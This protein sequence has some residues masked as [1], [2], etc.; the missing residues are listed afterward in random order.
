MTSGQKVAISLL[1]AI[2]V[3]AAFAVLSF[4]KLFSVVETRFYQNAIVR[5]VNGKLADVSA[6]LEQY[7]NDAQKKFAPLAENP[8]VKSSFTFDQSDENIKGRE[9]AFGALMNAVP[10]LSGVRII[11]KNGK[12]IHYSTFTDDILQQ[13]DK[14]ISYRLYA[15]INE[16]AYNEIDTA[17]E[18]AARIVCDPKN[19]RILYCFPLYDSFFV[20]RGTLV[21]YTAS[22]DFIREA[23]RRKLVRFTDKAVFAGNRKKPVFVFGLPN[24]ISENLIDAVNKKWEQGTSAIERIGENEKS[25][26]WVLLS[27]SGNSFASIENVRIYAAWLYPENLFVFSDSLKILLLLSVFVSTLLVIFLIFNIKSDDMNIIRERIKRFQLAVINEYVAAKTEVDWNMVYADMSRRKQEVREGIKRS[28]GSR[29]KRRSSEVDFLLD[30]SWNEIMAVLSAQSGIQS[31]GS[32]DVTA[33]QIKDLLEQI[34]L[35]G[36]VHSVQKNQSIQNTVYPAAQAEKNVHDASLSVERLYPENTQS[37]VLLSAENSAQQT[38][39][40]TPAQTLPESEAVL[41][42][43]DIDELEE[44]GELDEVEELEDFEDKTEPFGPVENV[45]PVE[46]KPQANASGDAG[47]EPLDV[48]AEIETEDEPAA[49]PEAV[50]GITADKPAAEPET[51]DIFAD[52]TDALSVGGELCVTETEPDTPA[53]GETLAVI[54]ETDMFIEQD[55]YIAGEDTP[56]TDTDIFAGGNTDELAV[57][58][59]E[60]IGTEAEPESVVLQP[61][62]EIEPETIDAETEFVAIAESESSAMVNADES[63]AAADETEAF[64]EAADADAGAD[65]AVSEIT[66][67]ADAE[68]D[69]ADEPAASIATTPEIEIED[70]PVAPAAG[71]SQTH[72]KPIPVSV[73]Q[74]NIVL[75]NIESET[76]T[77]ADSVLAQNDETDDG[78]ASA[79]FL[80]EL[81]F[82]F[83]LGKMAPPPSGLLLK[84]AAESILEKDGLFV[85]A[86]EAE[87]DITPADLNSEFQELVDSVLKI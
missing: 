21:F 29:A 24:G 52:G 71:S 61:A 10:A 19:E 37:T 62:A 49:A 51:E 14:A 9:D 4:T 74:K 27:G 44:L 84:P 67:T 69:N 22:S 34:L 8:S 57:L 59:A 18:Q 65:N 23:V 42:A 66:V 56:F 12:R 73:F 38:V 32:S 75:D 58:P 31:T 64:D 79:E 33:T 86:D 82:S 30:T 20:Y 50:A 39:E 80:E 47:I 45:E 87:L 54:D 60:K 36:G 83:T 26:V 72:S 55:A 53:A 76:K 46:L 48:L 17:D 40:Q 1:T 11:D 85:I 25:D 5:D 16:L 68:S 41:Q 81:P 3:F 2:L 15:D 7:I 35:Q 43:E 77:A 78:I 70:E 28:L 63:T 13:T 6:F